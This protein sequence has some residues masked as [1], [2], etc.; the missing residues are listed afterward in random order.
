MTKAAAA[1]DLL[2]DFFRKP[3]DARRIAIRKA[4]TLLVSPS[5]LPQ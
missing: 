3:L 1:P 5:R 4:T 2:S